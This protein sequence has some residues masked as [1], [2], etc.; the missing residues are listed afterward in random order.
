MTF[1]HIIRD[2]K[3]L[4]S[5]LRNG[6]ELELPEECEHNSR[7]IYH[8]LQYADKAVP[9]CLALS[10]QEIRTMAKSMAYI[11]RTDIIKSGI[12]AIGPV[13]YLKGL[14]DSFGDYNN[15]GVKIN[16]RNDPNELNEKWEL[17]EPPS[18]LNDSQD[19]EIEKQFN[20]SVYLGSY[21]WKIADWM[22]LWDRLPYIDT[23]LRIGDVLAFLLNPN[24]LVDYNYSPREIQKFH[25]V[26]EEQIKE[27]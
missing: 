21:V 14:T 7:V 17:P 1:R 26:L 6:Q 12:S 25:E 18:E 24:D 22:G 19:W 8:L 3:E 15:V 5:R 27:V 20:R 9:E 11:M 10:D 16:L 23:A 4:E 2:C 13:P